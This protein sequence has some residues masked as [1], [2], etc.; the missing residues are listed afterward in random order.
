VPRIL[1]RN[2]G[3]GKRTYFERSDEGILGWALHNAA[4]V[5]TNM[6]EMVIK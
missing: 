2:L 3:R 1:G 6:V 5:G 4:E